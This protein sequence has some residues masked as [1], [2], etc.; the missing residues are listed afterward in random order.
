[1]TRMTTNRTNFSFGKFGIIREIRY[2][3]ILHP[4]FS[5]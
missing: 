2:F 4:I 1:M 3:V 5:R